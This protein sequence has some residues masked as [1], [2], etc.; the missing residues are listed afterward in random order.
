MKGLASLL[1]AA[2]VAAPALA[3]AEGDPVRGAE[4]Y[5]ACVACHALA[6]G[7]HLTGP[8]LGGVWQRPA[9]TAEG[10]VRY[11]PALRDAGFSWD[12]AALDAWLA[13]P[14]AMIPG[15]TMAFR[16]I[17]DP[18]ARADLIAFLE[19]AGTAGGAE[20]LVAEGVIPDAYLRAQAPEPL[21]DAPPAAQVT[22]LRHCGDGYIIATADGGESMHW[23]QNIRL[24]ID[25]AETGPPPGV[26][27]IVGAGMQGDRFSVIFASLADLVALVSEG[28][29]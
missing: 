18:D 4:V 7:L 5:R 29:P 27:V 23:E 25:S 22:A 11:S 17:G 19:Q 28:C 15:T 8:S 13:D 6:P 9:G 24:K 2:L 20:R 14:Q 1:A 21:R 12:G 26:G 10:F 16:G 3:R